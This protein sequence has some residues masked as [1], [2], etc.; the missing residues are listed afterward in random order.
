M[1]FL[2]MYLL[3]LEERWQKISSQGIPQWSSGLDSGLPLPRAQVQSLLTELRSQKLHRAAKD[4]N[5][6][7]TQEINKFEG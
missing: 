3:Q 2:L 7:S 4:K 5:E 1:S 6:K